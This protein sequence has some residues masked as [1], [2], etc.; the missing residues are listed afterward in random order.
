MAALDLCRRRPSDAA[1]WSVDYGAASAPEPEVT[2]SALVGR[3]ENDIWVTG[4]RGSSPSCGLVA[5]K[6]AEG[7]DT[8]IDEAPMDFSSC[9]S[10]GGGAVLGGP[11]GKGA[12]TADGELVALVDPGIGVPLSFIRIRHV[13]GEDVALD[14]APRTVS[15]TSL[16]GTTSDD[17]YATRFSLV[18]RG[19]DIWTDGGA[20]G[21]STVAYEGIPITKPL[22]VVRGTRSDNVWVAG[23]SY[24]FHKTS[25]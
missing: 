7:W 22:H 11:V 8:V 24:V 9:V 19:S 18:E 6:T 20:W 13:P 1:A 5:H 2:L 10:S 12:S 23:E 25:P 3:S 16:W 17:L 21:V 4:Q 14:L 15:L